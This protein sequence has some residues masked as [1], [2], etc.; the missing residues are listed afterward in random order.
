[1]KPQIRSPIS[2]TLLGI[3]LG[4]GGV[5]RKVAP[6]C[7]ETLTMAEDPKLLAVGEQ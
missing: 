6:A 4:T 3:L 2:G 5:E 1:M 7:P